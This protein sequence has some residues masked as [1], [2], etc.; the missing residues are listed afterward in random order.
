[1]QQ[2]LKKALELDLALD[3]QRLMISADPQRLKQM[4]VNLLSNAVKF[5]PS[6]GAVRLEVA[7]DGAAGVVRFAVQDTGIGIAPED[8]ARLFQPFVQLDSSLSRQHEGSGL[9]LALVRR[10][11]E[12]HG[13]SI[14]VES[15]V[16]VGSRF[17]ISVPDH[18]PQAV[19]GPQSAEQWD[20][21]QAAASRSLSAAVSA[22]PGPE[23]A[24]VLLVE[25]SEAGLQ[26]VGGYLRAQ[27]YEVLV[28]R[29]GREALRQAATARPDLILMDIQLPGMDGLEAIQRIRAAGLHTTPIIALTALAMPGDRERCLE[30]GANTYLAK[31]VGIRALI[32]T[33]AE[34][35]AGSN[36]GH[37]DA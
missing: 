29:D 25:D 17:T 28:A 33:I 37:T 6:G 4:L 18:P 7:V 22:D 32:T 3:D 19:D 36:P 24:R 2:A 10:L 20:E 11:A 31:P 21:R 8:V 26:V 1:M 27:G 15:T 5:T 14:T 30:A 13:G 12:L 34:V 16:G 35:L 9:G 23:G